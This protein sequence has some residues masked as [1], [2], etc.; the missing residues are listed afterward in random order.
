MI[1]FKNLFS[2]HGGLLPYAD[3]ERDWLVLL[4]LAILVLAGVVVWN[5]RIFDTVAN[6]GVIGS[7]AT[8]TTPVF[9]K[10][11]LDMLHAIFANRAAEEKK[12]VSGE[13][14]FP[15]PVRPQ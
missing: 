11:S 14:R 6:G 1:T 13:Y 5:M 10:S 4:I 12:Y 8:S 3:P 9:S 2:R 15:D 7:P